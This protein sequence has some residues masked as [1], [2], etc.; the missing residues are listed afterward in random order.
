MVVHGDDF[1]IC[2]FGEDLKWIKK[3]MRS[4][5]EIKVRVVLGPEV[6]D[7]KGVV[8]LGRHVRWTKEGI[9]WKADPKHRQM[10]L[11]YFGFEEGTRA[12][13]VSGDKDVKFEEGDDELLGKKETKIYRGLAAR[14][15]CLSQDCP[16]L[17]HGSKAPSKEMSNPT[18]GSW[19]QMK[20]VA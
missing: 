16:D 18:R 6:G 11:E 2:G 3:L 8:I 1:T 5:F 4:W 19:K 15:N 9:E 10:I 14:L 12:L 13:S 20:K 17:Q 7:D